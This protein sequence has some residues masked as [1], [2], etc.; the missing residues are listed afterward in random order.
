[1]TEWPTEKQN[2]N[3]AEWL[4]VY[5]LWLGILA[6]TPSTWSCFG[7]L[8]RLQVSSDM[9][10]LPMYYSPS[11]V[12]STLYEVLVNLRTLKVKHKNKELNN[13]A[14]ECTEWLAKKTNNSA[15]DLL[16]KEVTNQFYGSR[17]RM[18]NTNMSPQMYKPY[19]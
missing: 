13:K 2:T 5:W 10:C 14:Q 18:C 7:L 3:G 12:R 8:L 1:M 6:G 17:I 4:K 9:L 15:T 16:F 11:L 19:N